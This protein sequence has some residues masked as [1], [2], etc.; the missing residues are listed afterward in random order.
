MY[1]AARRRLCPS[2]SHL[3]SHKPMKSL[4]SLSDA[5]LTDL[6]REANQLEDAP[7]GW[8]DAAVALWKVAPRTAV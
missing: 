8:V 2:I 5:E 6:A 4:H 1:Q 3:H 7:R